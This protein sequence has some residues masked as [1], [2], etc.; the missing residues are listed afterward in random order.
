MSDNVNNSGDNRAD[1]MAAVA[2][3]AIIVTSVALW[4]N[5]MPT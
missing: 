1:A 3:V 4:L 5:S 2:V